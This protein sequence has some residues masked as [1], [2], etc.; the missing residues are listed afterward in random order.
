MKKSVLVLI[1][2]M[3]AASILTGCSMQT[4]D[5]LYRLPKR[6]S[7]YR[8]LQSAMDQAMDELDFCAPLT[9]ENQQSVQMADVDGDGQQEYLVF[10]KGSNEMP[11]RILVFDMQNDLFIHTDTIESN[12]SAFDQVEYVQMDGEPGVEVIVGRQVSDQLVRSVSVYSFSSGEAEQMISTSYRKYVVVDFDEDGHSE[13]FVLRPGQTDLDKGIGE[14]YTVVN[15]IMERSNE[16]PMSGAVDRLKRILVGKLYDGK[17]A[18][19]VG[20]TVDETSLITDVFTYTGNVLTN[21]SLSAESGT[22]HRTLRN[23]YVYADDMDYDGIA[24]LPRLLDMVPIEGAPD[25]EHRDLILW[26]AMDSE[27]NTIDKLYTYYDSVGGWYLELDNSNAQRISVVCLGNLYEFYVWNENFD[28]AEKLLSI[29]ML[30]GQNREEQSLTN[31]RFVLLKT[32]TVT[33]AASLEHTARD[34]RITQESL[35]RD[36]HLVHRDWNMGEM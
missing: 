17:T 6:S 7:D 26:Y 32:D 35:I 14:L 22:S 13:L 31:G 27:G 33:Y 2:V 3:F 23:D 9:G 12:G 15:G 5:Q 8:N 30:T 1:C 36:F 11:L 21:I 19:Y 34:Y 29:Y 10:T 24:E 20:S 25:A 28:E 16:V 18:V 4:V